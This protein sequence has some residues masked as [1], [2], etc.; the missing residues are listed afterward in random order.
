M[1]RI[2]IFVLFSLLLISCSNLTKKE[3]ISF[4]TRE[5]LVILIENIKQDLKKGNT[6]LLRESFIPSIRN[7][8]T[9][10]EIEKIDFSKVNILVSKPA[11]FKDTAKNIVAFNVQ[12]TTFYYDVE[13]LLKNGEWKIVKFKERRG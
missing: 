12:E 8:F 4:E 7:G 3:E 5:N 2:F 10:E 6:Q 9:Q 11:F 13:Y 1:R